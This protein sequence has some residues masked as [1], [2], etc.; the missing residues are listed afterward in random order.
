MV[1]TGIPWPHRND[2]CQQEARPA[3]YLT[4]LSRLGLNPRRINAALH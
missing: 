3:P 1:L 2:V 4:D